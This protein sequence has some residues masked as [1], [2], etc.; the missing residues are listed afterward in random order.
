[1]SAHIS[2]SDYQIYI[3]N[4]EQTLLSFLSTN[5]Y[6]QYFILVDENTQQYCL[7]RI[8][9]LHTTLQNATIIAIKSGEAHKTIETTAQIWQQLLQN[10][11][12]RRALLLNLGG[13]VI[14][15]MGGF[16]AATYKRG[17]DFVQVPT[18]LLS[19]VDASV[20]GKLG[21]D[22][23]DIKNSIGSFANPKAVFVD[24]IFLQTL[25]FR[26]LRN[27]FAEV[28]KH[29]L[30]ADAH[31]WQQICQIANL[32]NADWDIIVAT[33]LHVKKRVVEQDPK[34]QNV[35]KILNFGHTVGHAIESYSLT[36]DA[37]PLLHG[38]A[39]A[40]GMIAELFLAVEAGLLTVDVALPVVDWLTA[41][42]GVHKVPQNAL[43][44]LVFLMLNDKKNANGT[45]QFALVDKIGHA[46]FDQSV[47]ST[48]IRQV[49][50]KCFV[51]DDVI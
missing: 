5:H 3:G 32:T 45:I 40:F 30:I 28:I 18:T 25:P 37:D 15:D 41:M 22:F 49:L 10:S 48:I 38:E 4:V 12:D 29:A 44:T 7:P 14:G 27:G 33:S 24:T 46:I 17:I 20:G 39:V 34:E 47:D 23:G 36:H 19:Q 16:A 31:Y 9:N 13:G 2:V 51:T 35:R 43:D 8:K 11:A 26:Q 42:F 50:A 1:M 21:I 6:S